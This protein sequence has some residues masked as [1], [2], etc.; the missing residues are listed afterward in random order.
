MLG[1]RPVPLQ[2]RLAVRQLGERTRRFLVRC[3]G[4]AVWGHRAEGACV[5]VRVFG[6]LGFGLWCGGH[7]SFLHCTGSVRGRPDLHV[8]PVGGVEAARLVYQRRPSPPTD[9]GAH[10][11][12][13]VVPH[14]LRWWRKV[15]R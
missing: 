9:G 13:M 3:G 15:L 7:G 11:G 12:L 2:L 14:T 8:A 10:S 4:R 5:A 1:V 6:A